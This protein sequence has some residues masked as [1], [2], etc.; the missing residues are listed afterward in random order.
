MHVYI[1]Y[2]IHGAFSFV[3]HATHAHTRTHTR[4][5]HIRVHVICKYPSNEIIYQMH[6]IITSTQK[7]IE[8]MW[9]PSHTGIPGNEKADSLA[10]E[11][12]KSSSST[13]INTLPYH[14]TKRS[15]LAYSLL[16]SNVC[17]TSWHEIPISNKLKSIKKK[18][19]I[20]KW[21]TQPSASMT[22]RSNQRKNKNRSHRPHP[23]THRKTRKT[24]C[25]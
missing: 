18:I 12:I 22:V 1:Y 10:N 13:S 4:N 2:I 25:L 14:D 23:R 20:T 24:T 21:C 8:F 6:I 5:L 16:M 19:T 15:I 11:A 7:A 3:Y 17:Q 9:V